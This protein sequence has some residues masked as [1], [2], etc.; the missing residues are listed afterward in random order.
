[1]PIPSFKS[2]GIVSERLFWGSLLFVVLP[3]HRSRRVRRPLKVLLDIPSLETSAT[4]IA[5]GGLGPLQEM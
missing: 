1:M 3:L 4:S 2:G 5:M